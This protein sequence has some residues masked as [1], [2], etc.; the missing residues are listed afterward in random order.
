[1]FSITGDNRYTYVTLNSRHTILISDYAL[2]VLSKV[3]KG[4]GYKEFE[5]MCVSLFHLMEVSKS[6]NS[7]S[8]YV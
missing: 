8:K 1:M 3:N 4:E 2:H 5:N 6:V 7:I